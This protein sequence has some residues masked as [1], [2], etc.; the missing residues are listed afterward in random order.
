MGVLYVV[1][2]WEKVR[3]GGSSHRHKINNNKCRGLYVVSRGS[4]AFIPMQSFSQPDLCTLFVSSISYLFHNP[5]SRELASYS[6]EIFPSISLASKV[7]IIIL[8]TTYS[9][10]SLVTFFTLLIHAAFGFCINHYFKSENTK[11][12]I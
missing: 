7:D 8:S 12:Q 9:L 4:Y 1:K 11:F 3:I 6:R 10:L 5:L 2:S